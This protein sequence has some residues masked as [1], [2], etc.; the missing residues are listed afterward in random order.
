MSNDD[1]FE[2][3]EGMIETLVITTTGI[4]NDLLE[5]A[6]ANAAEHAEFRQDIRRLFQAFSDH[7]RDGHSDQTP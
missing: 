2:R 3:L 5:L 7:Y 4:H 6:R 1:R